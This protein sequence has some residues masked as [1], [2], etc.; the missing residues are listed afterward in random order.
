VL[1]ALGALAGVPGPKTSE[2][3][4]LTAT[5]RDPTKPAHPALTFAYKDIF[6]LVTDPG[7]L[8]NL[9]GQPAHP[10]RATAM[11]AALAGEVKKLD[12]PHPSPTVAEPKP[13]VWSQ[14]VR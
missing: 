5:L 4:D 1:P 3:L 13:A 9:A 14:P 2:G 7:E 11:T 12:D 10:A 6:D 8:I